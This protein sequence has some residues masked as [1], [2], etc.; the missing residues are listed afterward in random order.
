MVSKLRRQVQ[1]QDDSERVGDLPTIGSDLPMRLNC[2]K[3]ARQVTSF[4]F[5]LPFGKQKDGEDSLFTVI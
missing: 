3:F 2:L 5:F 4:F 1:L